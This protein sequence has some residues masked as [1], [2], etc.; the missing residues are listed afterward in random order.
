MT[1]DGKKKDKGI[2]RRVADPLRPVVDQP[3]VG[4][5]K[6]IDPWENKEM[7]EPSVHKRWS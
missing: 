7:V 1:R 3:L 2:H 4:R 5:D 6:L